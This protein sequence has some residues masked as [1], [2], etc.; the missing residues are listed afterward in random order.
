MTLLATAD[1][2]SSLGIGMKQSVDIRSRN[3][4]FTAKPSGLRSGHAAPS[5]LG[6][7]WVEKYGGS[8]ASDYAAAPESRKELI[9]AE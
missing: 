3:G 8:A 9:A 2:S 4:S 5:G 1:E 7:Q 6:R